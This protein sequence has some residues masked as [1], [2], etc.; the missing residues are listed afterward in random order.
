M[1]KSFIGFAIGALSTFLLLNWLW[2]DYSW[3]YESLTQLVGIEAY[4]FDGPV[5]YDFYYDGILGSPYHQ[6]KIDDYKV[7]R[8]EMKTPGLVIDA[9]AIKYLCL[10]TIEPWETGDTLGLDMTIYLKPEFQTAILRLMEQNP[11]KIFSL[12]HWNQQIGFFVPDQFI[13]EHSASNLLPHDKPKPT[14]ETEYGEIV[15]KSREFNVRE[16]V[17]LA[18]IL[19]PTEP[20]E[21]CTDSPRLSAIPWW[22]YAIRDSWGD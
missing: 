14:E 4:A 11:E 22:D 19:S 1:L 6:D 16:M 17:W 10:S 8:L 2:E 3:D 15:L 7:I 18:K 5:N 9:D 21:A 12:T 20:P 13:V